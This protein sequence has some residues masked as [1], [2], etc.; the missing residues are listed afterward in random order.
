MIASNNYEKLTQAL[1]YLAQQTPTKSENKLKAIKLLWAADRYHIR[2]YSRLIGDEDYLAMKHGPVNSTAKD[3]AEEDPFNA[4]ELLQYSKEYIQ[5]SRY[6]FKSSKNV[7][8]DKLSKTDIEALRF[9]ID[10]FGKMDKYHLRDLTHEYP[11]WQKHAKVIESGQSLRESIDPVDFFLNPNIQEDP[12]ALEDD[13]LQESKQR[14]IQNKQ[15]A[16]ML[17]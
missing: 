15:V 14:Y 17:G 6:S 2:K 3:I 1:N 13:L 12:F 10:K 11:E 5:A 4:D 7:D 8:Y 9:A 16:A